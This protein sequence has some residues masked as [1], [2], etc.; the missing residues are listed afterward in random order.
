MLRFVARP[1][2]AK[3]ALPPSQGEATSTLIHPMAYMIAQP[4]S[5]IG[6]NAFVQTFFSLLQRLG[7][8]GLAQKADLAEKYCTHK[9][10]I[11]H[12]AGNRQHQ[13]H[14]VLMSMPPAP[15]WLIQGQGCH[16]H[17]MGDASV[18]WFGQAPPI[19]RQEAQQ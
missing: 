17:A 8:S 4:G 19:G 13:E 15:A 7:Q 14:H 3:V 9:L 12:Q 11:V 18:A 6:R 16:P 2:F 5:G 10:F 1:K